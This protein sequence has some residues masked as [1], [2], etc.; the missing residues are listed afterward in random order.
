M[1][2]FKT[3]KIIVIAIFCSIYFSTHS[4]A[5]D[6]TLTFGG[7]AGISSSVFTKDYQAVSERLTGIM[8]GGFGTYRITNFFSVGVELLYIQQ[9]ASN[10]LFI[11]T[12]IPGTTTNLTF[13][14]IDIPVLLIFNIPEMDK[15]N[16]KIFIGHSFGYN[17][18]VNAASRML[19][20]DNPVI[21]ANNYSDKTNRY[22]RLDFGI[23]AGIGTDF[24]ANNMIFTIDGRYRLGYTN[25]FLHNF[26]HTSFGYVC[27]SVGV[28]F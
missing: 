28:G 26:D 1:N 8:F 4:N 11:D 6:K 21:Y 20:N 17:F 3:F 15:V 14:T 25:I 18:R 27:V 22:E 7:R 16:P 5:Q 23:V 2:K 13:H 10:L 9:G 19:L 24:K 12:I